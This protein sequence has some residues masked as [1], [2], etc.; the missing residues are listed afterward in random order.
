MAEV[1]TRESVPGVEAPH[2]IRA[3]IDISCVTARLPT[4]IPSRT[5]GKAKTNGRC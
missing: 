2:G 1:E 4:I 3:A 5:R